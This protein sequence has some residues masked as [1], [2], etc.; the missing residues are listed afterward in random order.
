MDERVAFSTPWFEIIAKQ[1]DGGDA[2]HYSLRTNDYVSVV[3]VTQQG[4]ILLVRQF[5]PAVDRMT[6]ELPSGH[7]ENGETPELAARRELLEETGH[8][9]DIFEFLGNLSPDTGRLANRM[10][11]FFAA[12]ARPASETHA[13][14]EPGIEPI[15]FEGTLSKLIAERE[16]DSALNSAALLYAILRGHLSI[17]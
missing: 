6:L 12:G 2:P 17:E 15:F 1:F 5:R 14:L 4:R 10:W 7:V 16:F 13:P 8:V 3:A 9:A 11:C